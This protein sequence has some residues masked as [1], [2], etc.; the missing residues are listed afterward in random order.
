MW[1]QSKSSILVP[2]EN[3][4]WFPLHGINYRVW[5]LKDDYLLCAD[6]RILVGECVVYAYM[7]W[8]EN[9]EMIVMAGMEDFDL[10]SY[11]EH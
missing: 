6:C 7:C 2:R 5:H 3:K 9:F 1:Y 8:Y 11:L 4:N 10:T